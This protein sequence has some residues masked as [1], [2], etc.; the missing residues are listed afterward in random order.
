M[1]LR[2]LSDLAFRNL[3]EAVLRNSLTTLGIATIDYTVLTHY[4][5]DHDAGLIEL[6]NESGRVTGAVV[7]TAGSRQAVGARRGVILATGGFA[8]SGK[9]LRGATGFYPCCPDREPGLGSAH[10]PAAASR[11]AGR[12]SA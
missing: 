2:D 8:P 12:P 5:I 3:R 11:G 9:Y 1:K 6:L 4:H 7:E 10:G